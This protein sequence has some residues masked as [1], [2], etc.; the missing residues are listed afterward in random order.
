MS[1]LGERL[2]GGRVEDSS[3]PRPQEDRRPRG[4]EGF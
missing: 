2:A 1:F 4:L 3:D